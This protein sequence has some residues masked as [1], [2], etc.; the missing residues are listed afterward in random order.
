MN[1][2]EGKENE[3]RKVPYIEIEHIPKY[4]H[5]NVCMFMKV[6]DIFWGHCTCGRKWQNMGLKTWAVAR[7]SPFT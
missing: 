1:V 7:N 2:K 3:S 4:S 5:D 6:H